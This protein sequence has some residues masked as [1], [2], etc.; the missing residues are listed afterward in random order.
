MPRAASP[1]CLAKDVFT[2]QL[3]Q[4]SRNTDR[5]VHLRGCRHVASVSIASSL[6]VARA[7][8]DLHH[9]CLRKHSSQLHCV[10][11]HLS[12]ATPTSTGHTGGV[13]HGGS[14]RDTVGAAAAICTLVQQERMKNRPMF[15]LST[16]GTRGTDRTSRWAGLIMKISCTSC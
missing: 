1:R 15:Q 5:A 14:A 6:P 16:L 7:S 2:P 11:L 3:S 10:W 13:H 12:C 8:F 4:D 9:T